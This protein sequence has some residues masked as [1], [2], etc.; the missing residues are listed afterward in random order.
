MQN[1]Q[2]VAELFRCAIASEQVFRAVY[3]GLAR[4]FASHGDIADFWQSMADDEQNHAVRLERLRDSLSQ[5][6]ASSASDY[7]MH[8]KAQSLRRFSAPQILQRI[9]TLDDAYEAAHELEHSEVNLLFEFLSKHF[10]SSQEIRQ[11][12]ALEV[13][14][15]TMKLLNFFHAFG[16]REQRKS[17]RAEE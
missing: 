13:K 7:E 2:T 14:E 6:Q 16:G 11:M 1:E 10:S 17:M 12:V 4:K 8:L 5:E 9:Q 15:H 3:L